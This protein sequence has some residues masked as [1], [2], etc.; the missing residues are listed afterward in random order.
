MRDVGSM[1]RE[2]YN[3]ETLSLLKKKKKKKKEVRLSVHFIKQVNKNNK[4]N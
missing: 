2:L 1:C 3:R 4:N